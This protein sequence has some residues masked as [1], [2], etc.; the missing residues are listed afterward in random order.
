MKKIKDERLLLQ[1]LKNIRMAFLVQSV[2]IVAILLYE[3]ITNGLQSTTDNPLWVLFILTGLVLTSLNLK[4]SVDMEDTAAK[5]KAPPYYWIVILAGLLGLAVALLT[6]YT[7][8]GSGTSDAVIIGLVVF[9]CFLIPYSAIH[10]LRK[11][12]A[13]EDS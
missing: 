9:F 4:I 1:N 11:K 8:G 6:K 3:V 5:R 13:E 12:R 7:A 2:G 10:Y